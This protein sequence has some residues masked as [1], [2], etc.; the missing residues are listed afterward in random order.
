MDYAEWLKRLREDTAA[1]FEELYKTQFI[2]VQAYITQNN[3]TTDDARDIFQEAL[4]VLY[5]KA[6]SQDFELRANPGTYLYSTAT[7]KWLNHITRKKRVLSTDSQAHLLNQ[8]P[9]ENEIEEKR[10]YDK[11]TVL[12][13]EVL[14]EIGDKCQQL[15]EYVIFEKLSHA[16][17]AAKMGFDTGSVKVIKSRCMKTYRKKIKAHPKF[18]QI[19]A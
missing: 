8:I 14:K 13:Y 17:V 9:I 15:L 6:M 2:K 5:K 12:A 19:F 16:E 3:G 10:I 18:N 1:A 7:K 4:I 11:K